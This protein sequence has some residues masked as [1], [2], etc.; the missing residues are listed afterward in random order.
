MIHVI[1]ATVVLVLALAETTV[2][3]QWTQQYE[4]G[5]HTA[6]GCPCSFPIQWPKS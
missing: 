4:L 3:R 5:G 1:C 2:L 6:V